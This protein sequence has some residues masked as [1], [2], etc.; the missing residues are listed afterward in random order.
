MCVHQGIRFTAAAHRRCKQSW[1]DLIRYDSQLSGSSHVEPAPASVR[2]HLTPFLDFAFWLSSW[3]RLFWDPWFCAAS[4][5]NIGVFFY[6]VLGIILYSF[7]FSTL[8]FGL[9]S[10]I[11]LIYLIFFRVTW[12]LEPILAVLS[13]RL[14]RSCCSN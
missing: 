9:N 13:W 11:L 6:G 2:L 1:Q 10:S 4:G 7:S 3:L 8:F 12:L 5:Q 14:C